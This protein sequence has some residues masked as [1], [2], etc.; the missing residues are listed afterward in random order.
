M[1]KNFAVKPAVKLG[2]PHTVGGRRCAA[3]S[4]RFLGSMSLSQARCNAFLHDGSHIF[5][6][7]WSADPWGNSEY[8]PKCWDVRRVMPRTS[9][10]TQHF[11]DS[12]NSA[13]YCS[14]DW[15]EGQR[16]MPNFTVHASALFGFDDA[17]EPICTEVADL[18]QE[19]R[20]QDQLQCCACM[21]FLE[22]S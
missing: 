14:S 12:L 1:V 11:F 18:R 10:P 15:Y 13:A 19:T 9:Q 17:I 4:C 22:L 21:A 6:H 8:G 5:R 20:R 2:T 16:A 3:S 7:M